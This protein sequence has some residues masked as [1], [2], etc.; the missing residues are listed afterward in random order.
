MLKFKYF[1]NCYGSIEGIETEVNAWLKDN[2]NITVINLAMSDKYDILKLGVI[3]EQ[4]DI[5]D[6]DIERTKK[7]IEALKI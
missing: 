5:T 6:K 3:Y 2:Q 7:V 4:V 1:H